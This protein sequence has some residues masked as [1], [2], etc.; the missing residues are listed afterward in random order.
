[1]GYMKKEIRELVEEMDR[2]FTLPNDWNS[3][4]YD[5]EKNHNLIIKTG[6]SYYCT[7]CQQ[8]FISKQ[9]IGKMFVCPSCN[10]RSEVRDQRSDT[11]LPG[12]IRLTYGL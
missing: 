8:T 5:V 4:F 2:T 7:C 9:N 12:K 6:K 10:I 11:D 3:F 1:M